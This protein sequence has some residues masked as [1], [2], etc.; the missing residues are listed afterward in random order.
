M[1]AKAIAAAR[2]LLGLIFTVFGLN[3][4][5]HFIPAAAHER[6]AGG[7]RRALFATGYFFPLLKSTEV[8]SGLLLLSGRLVPLALTVPRARHREHRGLHAFLAPSGIVLPLVI[9]A[10]EVFL[11][12]GSGTGACRRC[13]RCGSSPMRPPKGRASATSR[14]R[15]GDRGSKRRGKRARRE[16]GLNPPQILS[17]SSSPI[18]GFSSS[19]PGLPSAYRTR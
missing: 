13:S 4:F 18:C 5:F 3:G 16:K 8:I 1:K 6:S 2:I 9:V 11:A 19:D 12:R 15:R 14:P 10:L 7:F 17:A